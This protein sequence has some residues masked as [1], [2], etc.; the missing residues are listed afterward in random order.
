MLV[1]V[2]FTTE[3][4]TVLV[5]AV[6]V[7]TMLTVVVAR[8]EGESRSLCGLLLGVRVNEFIKCVSELKLATTIAI[9]YPTST[10]EDEAHRAPPRP[11][12]PTRQLP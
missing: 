5:S 10:H 3:L 4:S 2:R 12:P 8:L 6:E 9:P 11:R 7:I 1:V